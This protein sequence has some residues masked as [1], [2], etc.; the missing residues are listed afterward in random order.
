MNFSVAD[1]GK[2]LQTVRESFAADAKLIEEM[3]GLSMS[4]E[5]W[6]FNLRKS[7]TE[8]LVRL[9]VE[10]RGDQSLLVDKTK[11]LRKLINRAVI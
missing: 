9:N 7:N 4:F 11:E 6:R 1:P 8:A 3:D 5:N 10:T 2:C